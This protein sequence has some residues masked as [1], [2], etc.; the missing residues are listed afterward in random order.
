VLVTWAI[1][2]LEFAQRGRGTGPWTGLLFLGEFLSPLL[3]AGFGAAAGGL[4]PALGI[5]AGI[6]AVLAVVTL[7]VVPRGAAP[8]NV[9]DA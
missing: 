9:T 6:S 1:N 7:L 5:L 8:L 4:R 3:I 2:R